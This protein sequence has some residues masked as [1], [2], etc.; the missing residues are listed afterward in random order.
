MNKIY[1]H[2]LD[3]NSNI[4]SSKSSAVYI[5]LLELG[6]K[7]G[8]FLKLCLFIMFLNG[9]PLFAQEAPWPTIKLIASVNLQNSY[10]IITFNRT[11]TNGLDPTFDAGLL[12][13][14]SDLLIYSFLV[15]DYQ[16]V[17]FAI[18]ALPDYGYST[19]TIPIGLDFKTGGTVVFSAELSNLLAGYKVLFEDKVTGTITDL[20]NSTYPISIPANSSITSR[21]QLHYT[22]SASSW[23]GTV[24]NDWNLAGNWST[25]IVPTALDDVIISATTNSPVVNQTSVSPA[26]CRN[27]LIEQGGILTIAAGKAL[28]VNGVLTNNSMGGIIIQSDVLGTGSLITGSTTG[29]G[30][31][32]AER[33]MTTGAWHIVSSPLAGEDVSTFL[34][35][36]SIVPLKNGNRGMMDYNPSLNNWN[37]FFLQMQLAAYYWDQV[38]D[39]RCDRTWMAQFSLQDRYRLVRSLLLP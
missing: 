1:L 31:A 21:F 30:T 19:I 34:T 17:K 22:P 26:F 27:L 2:S 23:N 9:S 29:A 14:G 24:S 37:F 12:G 36:N 32:L 6:R 15:Q 7:L 33:Y 28:T 4:I 13:G 39:F 35:A 11:M 25:G 20:S 18:Q 5:Q 10:T 16:S 38:K 3:Q 8:L